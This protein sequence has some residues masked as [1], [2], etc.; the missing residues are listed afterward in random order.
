MLPQITT[1]GKKGSFTFNVSHGD[2][3]FFKRVVNV[4]SN[5]FLSKEHRLTS[6]E[7]EL[8]YCICNFK[9]S[10]SGS[11]FSAS[12]IKNFFSSFGSKRLLQIWLPKL[13]EKHWVKV[14]NDSVEFN[15]VGIF[16]FLSSEEVFFNISY[17]KTEDGGV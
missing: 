5:A 4:M 12:N 10:G 1:N 13:V 16:N 7:V 14:V 15:S 6:R 11:M 2:Y 3:E 8:L 17:K 9:N